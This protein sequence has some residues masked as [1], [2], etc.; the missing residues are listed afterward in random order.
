MTT[1][2]TPTGRV[3]FQRLGEIDVLIDRTFRAP[4]TD[5]WASLTE[6]ERVARWIG[7]WTG[8]AGPGRTITFLMTAE[9]SAEPEE[10]D[11]RECVPPRRLV[12][13]FRQGDATLEPWRVTVELEG[14]DEV[15]TLRFRTTVPEPFDASDV[16]PGWEYY[17]DRLGAAITESPMPE[18]DAYFPSQQPYYQAAIA[19]ARTGDGQGV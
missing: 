16:G 15:T 14:A 10:V 17:I 19:A 2:A 13:D 4:V 6:P 11:I 7:T 12:I 9:E 8:E 3:L 1:S 5:V 18:W